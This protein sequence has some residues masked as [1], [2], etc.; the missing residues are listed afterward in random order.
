[1]VVSKM[2]VIEYYRIHDVLY[3]IILVA[4]L[5]LLFQTV[6]IISYSMFWLS[7]EVCHIFISYL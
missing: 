7:F 5:T 1:M 4:F 3:N 2:R 6:C